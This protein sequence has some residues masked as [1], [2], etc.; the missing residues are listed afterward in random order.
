MLREFIFLRHGQTAWNAA[1]RVMGRADIPLDRTGIRQALAARSI[2]AALPVSSVWQSPLRRCRQT[3]RLALGTARPR[4]HSLPG[5]A[6][7]D[8]GPHEGESAAARPEGEEAGAGVETLAD[9]RARVG[10][11]LAQ[12]ADEGLPLIVAHSGTFRVICA[13]LDIDA[14]QP[15]GNAQPLLVDGARRQVRVMPAGA[16]PAPCNRAVPFPSPA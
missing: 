12:I 15:A 4:S 7:R 9:F 2:L 5:L 11:A 6:E 13:L 10:H 8:W 16:A 1:G 3:A 14:P